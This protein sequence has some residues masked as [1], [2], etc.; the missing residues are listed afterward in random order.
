[1]SS[2]DNISPDLV[3]LYALPAGRGTGWDFQKMEDLQALQSIRWWYE[4]GPAPTHLPA[5]VLQSTM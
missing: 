5:K 2:P 4:G 1:M 3:G